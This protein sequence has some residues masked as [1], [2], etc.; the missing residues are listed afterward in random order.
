MKKILMGQNFKREGFK[1]LEGKFEIIYPENNWF[2]KDEII[3]R[4]ADIDVLVPNFSFP[5]DGEIME[6]GKN[7]KLIANYGVGYD[8]IDV[9][10]ATKRGIAVTNTPNAVL[11][12]T[13]ELCFALILATARRIGY[14]N[15]KLHNKERVDWS[16][17]G[18]LG[19]PVYGQTLGIYGMVRIVQV[20]ASRALNSGMYI[21]FHNRYR[22]D[23]DIDNKYKSAVV[24]FHQLQ[25]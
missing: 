23:T 1:E 5:T 2:K 21:L 13:A 19:M 18:D 9:D 20:V 14:Y 3:E 22:L 11:E 10:Y 16:S 17:L 4:I 6:A 15:T 25:I 7:L 8:N 24:Q 12:P